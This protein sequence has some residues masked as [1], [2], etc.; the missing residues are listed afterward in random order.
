[1]SVSSP[2]IIYRTWGKA[3]LQRR[4]LHL[5]GNLSTGVLTKEPGITPLVNRKGHWEHVCYVMSYPV[6][7][8]S[9]DPWYHV[10]W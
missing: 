8:S 2:G 7:K 5:R 4:R 10:P 9:K 1:M 6:R 3:E